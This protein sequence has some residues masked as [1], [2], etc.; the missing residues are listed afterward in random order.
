MQ[1]FKARF[2][3]GYLLHSGCTQFKTGLQ[4]CYPLHTCMYGKLKFGFFCLK[5]LWC[6]LWQLRSCTTNKK[7]IL[8]T[9]LEGKTMS[10]ELVS[11]P[12]LTLPLWKELKLHVVSSWC[13]PDLC[14]TQSYSNWVSICNFSIHLKNDKLSQWHTIRSWHSQISAC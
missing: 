12:K 14:V 4:N 10:G 11:P 1:S 13:S 3:Y 9:C 2:W 8:V 6:M 7:D 5:M